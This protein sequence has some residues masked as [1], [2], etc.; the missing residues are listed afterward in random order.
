ML[1][2]C[3]I[4]YFIC[5]RLYQMDGY[6]LLISWKELN[7]FLRQISWH[8]FSV[9]MPST[10]NT[11]HGIIRF[12]G[13]IALG[14]VVSST[15]ITHKIAVYLLQTRKGTVS[16]PGANYCSG[17]WKGYCRLFA[18]WPLIYNILPKRGKGFS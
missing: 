18:E 3:L 17:Q 11:V 4:D 10:K 16:T 15:K 12:C 13:G 6:L 8:I 9:L 2:V 7:T 1:L 14:L 5:I